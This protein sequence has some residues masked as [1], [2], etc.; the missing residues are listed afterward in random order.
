M[1]EETVTVESKGPGEKLKYARESLGLSLWQVASQLYL[2]ER[3]MKA[4]EEDDYHAKLP[5]RAFIRGYLRSYAKLL[6]LS[7]EEILSDLDALGVYKTSQEESMKSVTQP[8]VSMTG[9]RDKFWF[10]MVGCGLLI[11]LSLIVGFTWMNSREEKNEEV[12]NSS[13]Q[14]EEEHTSA[15]SELLKPESSA[16]PDAVAMAPSSEIIPPS[17]PDVVELE[18]KQPL[19]G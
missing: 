18:E 5:A 10:G 6:K 15:L 3:V 8:T 12:L 19:I 11:L 16:N 13:L 2:P 7:P 1:Q 4:L 14:E 9:H 17:I